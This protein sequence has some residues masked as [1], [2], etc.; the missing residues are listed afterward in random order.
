[1]KQ[2]RSPNSDRLV[3]QRGRARISS[4]VKK[5]AKRRDARRSRACRPGTSRRSTGSSSRRPPILRMSCSPD[6]AWITEPAP[7]NSSALKKACV[8]R[9]KTAD[10][11][12]AHAAGQEHVAELADRRV[13]EHLLDVGLHE[14]DRGGDERGGG[15]D[16]PR[17]PSCAVAD[18]VVERAEPRDHVDAGGDH[19][20]G[21]DERARPASGPPS[22]RAARRRAGSARSCRRRPRTAAGTTTVTDA[23]LARAPRAPATPALS[24]MSTRSRRAEGVEDQEHAQDQAR[25]ADAVDDERL[26]ARRRTRSSS[27][28]RSRSAGRSRARRPPSRRTCSG[29]LPPSTS[30]SM[31]NVNR[32]RYE[33]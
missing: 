15:A 33:K 24:A 2:R 5:P 9:W 21:V 7:R 8:K 14:R 30:I 4:L 26:L 32:F 13:G 12:G 1:M 23:E 28:T 22:R 11:E 31:K 29:R 20:G 18:C 6:S 10:A 25:V 19:G 27:C 3:R 16:R 17:P